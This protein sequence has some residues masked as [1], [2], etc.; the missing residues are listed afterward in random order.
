M[1]RPNW[2]TE[3]SVRFILRPQRC[4]KRFWGLSVRD[5]SLRVVEGRCVMRAGGS[6]TAPNSHSFC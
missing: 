3:S 5:L 2:P 1:S 6:A 4:S